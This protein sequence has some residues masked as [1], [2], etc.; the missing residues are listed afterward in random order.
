MIGEPDFQEKI[1][2]RLEVAIGEKGFNRPSRG[3]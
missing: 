2:V 3:E 1:G